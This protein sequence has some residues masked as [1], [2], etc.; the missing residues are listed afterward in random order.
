MYPCHR[1]KNRAAMRLPDKNALIFCGLFLVL[2][3]G[4]GHGRCKKTGK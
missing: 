4:V 1:R 2:L 3:F